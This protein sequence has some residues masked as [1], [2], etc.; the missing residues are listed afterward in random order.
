[1]GIY[2]Y[3]CVPEYA[4]MYIPTHKWMQTERGRVSET[5]SVNT[6][7]MQPT[8]RPGTRAILR[9]PSAGNSGPSHGMPLIRSCLLTVAPLTVAD[10]WDP[11]TG[12]KYLDLSCK[13]CGVL[14]R[15]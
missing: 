15:S 2:I 10:I 13:Q 12:S 9:L 14:Y 5:A 1:M 4:C 7:E 8:C 6:E 11:N 3:V